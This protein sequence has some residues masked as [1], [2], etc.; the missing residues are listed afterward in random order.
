ML[1]M[2]TRF[3]VALFSAIK[4]LSTYP[5]DDKKIILYSLHTPFLLTA[6]L[7]KWI[8]GVHF[9]IIVTDFPEYMGK[10]KGVRRFLK[11]IDS[12]LIEWLGTQ[13]SGF[14][15]VSEYAAKF[16]KKWQSIPAVIIEGI[17]D[18]PG[19]LPP[20]SLNQKKSCAVFYSGG[21][22][23]DY[24]VK[25]LVDAAEFLPENYEIWICGTGELEEYV[26]H[27]SKID[28]RVKYL[29]LLQPSEVAV[30][31]KQAD[32]L[33]NPR[34]LEKKFV[35]LSFPSKILEYLSYQMPVLTSRVPSIP[36]EY[37][38]FLFYI[39]EVS[40]RG[41]AESVMAIRAMDQKQV[42]DRVNNGINFIFKK[43][44]AVVQCEKFAH[45]IAGV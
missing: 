22:S 31:A 18:R 28:A 33:I 20:L 43:K 24:G 40:P 30:K 19:D 38:S 44:S 11:A 10:S 9:Y 15:Y 35:A 1:K 34:R 42:Q 3:V 16:Y 13:S 25:D 36:D 4:W 45:I 32:I 39:N 5:Q 14:S 29:G 37:D 2:V 26:L 41:I 12:W 8:F 6:V 23:Y 27:K 7:L 17:V 21:L